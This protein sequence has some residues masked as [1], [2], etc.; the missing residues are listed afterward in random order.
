MRESLFAGSNGSEVAVGAELADQP[1]DGSPDSGD[2]QH[3]FGR[4][5]EFRTEM[6]E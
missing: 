4:L 6:I 1:G 3:L 2:R 5:P